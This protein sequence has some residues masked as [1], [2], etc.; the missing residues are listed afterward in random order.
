LLRSQASRTPLS[1]TPPL[2]NYELELLR[3]KAFAEKSP[4]RL[5]PV[6]STIE[7]TSRRPL[8]PENEQSP[9]KPIGTISFAASG[10]FEHPAEKELLQLHLDL[11]PIRL[12]QKAL[13]WVGLEAAY[14]R[15]HPYRHYVSLAEGKSQVPIWFEISFTNTA[16]TSSDLLNSCPGRKFWNISCEY[17]SPFKSS[18]GC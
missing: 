7:I 4:L 8:E 15:V 9:G 1:G 14:L 12:P 16:I 6:C 13:I 17:I 2:Q 10:S 5:L 18:A 3:S 11:S